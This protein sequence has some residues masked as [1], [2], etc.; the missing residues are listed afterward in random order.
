MQR[1]L[2][3][4]DMFK[5]LPLEVMKEIIKNF[6]H[7]DVKKF[8][9]AYPYYNFLFQ[10]NFFEYIENSPNYF[11]KLKK[12][13]SNFQTKFLKFEK[14]LENIH[15]YPNDK[16]VVYVGKL[17]YKDFMKIISIMQENGFTFLKKYY[18]NERQKATNIKNEIFK[19]YNKQ[20]NFF[21][22]L[23]IN[24]VWTD[25]NNKKKASLTASKIIQNLFNK[26]SGVYN[27][28]NGEFIKV[29]FISE[30]F[31][32][33]IDLLDVPHIHI[34]DHI[35]CH[36]EMKQIVGRVIRRGAQS[37]KEFN[38]GWNTNVFQYVIKLNNHTM[39]EIA[40]WLDENVWVKNENDRFE[41]LLKRSSVD[42]YLNENIHRFHI[43]KEKT[44]LITD[45]IIPLP[46]PD[47]NL[48]FEYY[49]NRVNE[50][51]EIFKT[52]I[53]K[54]ENKCFD[55]ENDIFDFTPQQNF[56]RHYFNETSKINNFLL[57]HSVGSGKT[58]TAISTASSSFEQQG[59]NII[60]ITRNSLLKDVEKNLLGKQ[61]AHLEFRSKKYTKRQ[62][63]IYLKKNGWIKPMSYKSFENFLFKTNSQKRHVLERYPHQHVL[64]NSLVIIDEFHRLDEKFIEKLST[65][66]S[67]TNFIKKPKVLLMSATPF[68][69]N[70][71]KI[72]ILNL[73]SNEKNDLKE[74]FKGK[75]SYF[76]ATNDIRYF[77]K[78]NYKTQFINISKKNHKYLSKLQL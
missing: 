65:L 39:R 6:N 59:R 57:W 11:I 70:F 14:I 53:Q 30:K 32:E 31:K 72:F 71:H 76:D 4:I 51:Y 20:Q 5:N 67:T 61:T 28:V 78:I 13:M 26:R 49:N 37:K 35:V 62:R 43:T 16:H 3:P 33:G 55:K 41:E 75:I 9:R 34:M 27:N 46:E 66:L 24:T 36:K 50:I 25:S 38:N 45:E 48:S 1:H 52:F 21:D 19:N 18:L 54:I 7:K 8:T 10:N 60:F 23:C 77:P 73:F 40:H 47:I 69:E 64:D 44:S 17:K 74:I 12:A 2:Y 63:E 29:L 42:S 15:K 56:I 68:L 58:A 22:F